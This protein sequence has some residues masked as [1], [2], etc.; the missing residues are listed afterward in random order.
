MVGALAAARRRVTTQAE[1][2][3]SLVEI[4]PQRPS[5]RREHLL[6]RLRAAL[7]LEPR[8]VVGR[9]VREQGDLL[10]PQSLRSSPRTGIE[11]HVVGL[12]RLPAPAQE[13]S[14]LSTIHRPGSIDAPGLPN[15]GSAIRL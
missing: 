10:A 7:L 13:V 3:V 15:Q 2:V 5:D 6:R 8:V 4:E 14:E 11:S 12:Q 9:H 1:Q